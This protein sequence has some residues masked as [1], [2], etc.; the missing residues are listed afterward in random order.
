MSGKA[1]RAERRAMA[2]ALKILVVDDE[3]G[4]RT[5]VARALREFTVRAKHLDEDVGFVV[6][7]AES[8]EQALEVLLPTPAADPAKPPVDILL[9]DHKL[10]GMSGLEVLDRIA[11]KYEGMMTVMITAYA[12]LETAVAAISTVRTTFWP[13]PSRRWS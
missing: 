11:G 5:G 4:M 10:P 12:S 6:E 3:P 2:D 8:A 7:Q 9:L 1:R 13:S